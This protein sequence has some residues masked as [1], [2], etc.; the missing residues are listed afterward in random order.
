MPLDHPRI[1]AMR[2]DGKGA[3]EIAKELGCSRG[4]DYKALN[5][6]GPSSGC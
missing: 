2:A 5:F 4:A 6:N 3:T 1:L